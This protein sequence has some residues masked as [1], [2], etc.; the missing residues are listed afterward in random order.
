MANST[1]F[2]EVFPVKIDAIPPLTAYEV[3]VH[4][5]DLV[6]IGRR[7]ADR[8]SRR[9]GSHNVW[10]DGVLVTNVVQ[11]KD[12]LETTLKE[13]RT[14]EIEVFR[15][16]NTLALI[17]D[18]QPN[19]R[20]IADFVAFGMFSRLHN[21]IQKIL[22][23]LTQDLDGKATVER[24][25]E[26]KG[27]VV[28]DEPA[29]SISVKSRVLFN[30]D[31][32]Q[33]AQGIQNLD[34]LVGLWVADKVPHESGSYFKGEILEVIGRLGQNITREEV[35]E[36]AKR[37]A[38][39]DLIQ[40]A[41][42][43]EIVVIA[44]HNEY[45]YVANA[46]NIVLMT[47]H[48]IRFGIDTKKAQDATWMNAAERTSI[49]RQIVDIAKNNGLTSDAYTST[50]KKSL[51]YP[52]SK[53]QYD[54][55]LVYGN[56]T[57]AKFNGLGI[58]KLIKQNGM[59][60]YRSDIGTVENPL[61][62][63]FINASNKQPDDFKTLLVQELEELHA[64]V[65]QVEILQIPN[66]SRV[67]LERA[68][69]KLCGA[70]A[71]LLVAILP[72]A[73]STDASD[74]GPYLEFKTLTMDVVANQVIDAATLGK[75]L[76]YVIPNI[77]IGIMGKL[78]NVP[79][80]LANPINYADIIVGIDIAR[81]RKKGGGSYNAAAMAQVYQRNG[82]FVRCR[83]VESPI[84]GETV[85]PQ[86]LRSLFPL[87]EFEGKTVVVHRDGLFR[88][89]EKEVI[90]QHINVDLGGTA[91]LVEVIKSGSPRIYS[92]VER[93]GIGNPALG[94]AMLISNEEAFLV[95]SESKNA[96]PNPLH[97]RTEDPFTIGK[98]LH[99]VLMLTLLHHGSLRRP[100]API[101]IHYSD[102]IGYL[103]LRGV[104]PATGQSNE[105]YWL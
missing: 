89:D 30:Q 41:T 98:A 55:T 8:L 39:R 32:T 72:D 1:I 61:H 23:P 64:K 38:S 58:I 25:Y 100:K 31:L 28:K 56:G 29:V 7:L 68:V 24:E 26:V 5:S 18:W 93:Q 27:W 73:D 69:N 102:K 33:Y 76:D 37:Q 85:P 36:E 92:H 52:A 103:A 57:T 62:I 47:K 2:S 48:Y 70:G 86:V 43:N 49:V 84:S 101:T 14:K 12:V 6:R 74:W 94:T 63:G 16:F 59:Y 34:E 65:G 60:K 50:N 87:N 11:P 81:M 67:Q 13:I 75:K 4:G 66:S 78:G 3:S 19:A 97:I 77:A 105:L 21:D 82:Q 79:Y 53:F 71:N 10:T 42:A 88:G 54:D 91:F 45:K 22:D 20:V 40:Q 51:F 17:S 15:N 83:I 9:F 80:A 99:S 104:K 35:L 95:A 90:K 96:T 44:G 46:L